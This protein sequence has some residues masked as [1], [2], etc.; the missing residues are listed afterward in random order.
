MVPGDGA[1][2]SLYAVIESSVSNDKVN[3]MNRIKRI[4]AYP[5]VVPVAKE[6]VNCPA[7]FD[8]MLHRDK[9][10][11]EWTKNATFFGDVPIF[12]VKIEGESGPAGWADSSRM[13][14]KELFLKDAG[15]FIGKRL[16]E[17][18]A[19]RPILDVT[20]VNRL[21]IETGHQ[22]VHRG[23]C[24]EMAALDWRA[25][26][27]D[28]P[29]WKM[30]GERNLQG[31]RVE[32]WSGFRT[33]AG[34]EQVAREAKAK[35]F[36]GLKLKANLD[37]DVGPVTEAVFRGAGK[38]FHLNIDP[39]GR[40]DTVEQAVSR[41]KSMLATSSRVLLEDPIYGNFAAVAE[42]RK[43]TGIVMAL[44]IQMVEQVEEARRVDACDVFNIGGIFK[45]MIDC[46]AAAHKIGKPVWIGSGC[47]TGLSDLMAVHLGVTMPNCTVGS[48]LIGNMFR[49]D[50]LLVTPIEFKGGFAQVP[51]GPGRGIETDLDAIERHRVAEPIVVE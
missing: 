43:Q 41:A 17:I 12:A 20:E 40:W 5:L 23:K 30:F 27:E 47:D 15:K 48:D 45:Q 35:G 7:F 16:D 3:F 13:I 28:V 4:T 39:N 36:L 1:G 44:T 34:A 26:N 33:P 49:A 18:D 22:T 14:D 29:L 8:Q 38:D 9:E 10:K 11:G 42:V 46:A 31:L 25:L 21:A 51:D 24:M 19:R 2:A 37:I 6:R 32:A 50:D